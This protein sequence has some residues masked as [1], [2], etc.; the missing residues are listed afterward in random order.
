MSGFTVV[1]LAFLVNMGFSAAPTPL[2]V[3]YQERDHFSTIMVT[4]VYAAYAVGVIGA[5]FLAGHLS[6]WFGR[7]K[8][9]VTA[10]LVDAAS[11]LLFLTEPGVLGLLL[12]RIVC[13]VSIGLTTATATAY[14]AELYRGARG[15]E[16]S[17]GRPQIVAAGANLGGI[18][19]GPLVAGLLAQY[20]PRPLWLPYLVFDAALLLLAFLVLLAPETVD[21][22]AS[23][24]R[25]RPQRIAVP[26]Q[27][28]SLFLAATATG[29]ATFSVFGVLNSLVP[30]FL[31]G[32][33]HAHSHALAGAV[34]F[35]AFA[36]GALAQIAASRTGLRQIIRL[37]RLL[38]LPGLAALTAGMWIPNLAV[39]ITGSVLAG[40][41]VGL[42]FRGALIAAGES[43]PPHSR[44]EV[45]AGFF[46]GTYVGLSVPV[47]G[48][49]LATRYAS[50]RSVMLV[51]VILVAAAALTSSRQMI[52]HL[53]TGSLRPGA[54]ARSPGRR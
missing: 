21:A 33:L 17:P 46:L 3:L 5:L 45:L 16:G 4:V 38:L 13:G 28:R 31:A 43:A 26:P 8:V 54:A 25:Y 42:S 23:R 7:R 35:T 20:A 36:S 51:F 22:S 11:G 1:A 29:F 9:L 32:A 14:L 44:A 2:Y 27:A 49:G 10:L 15:T 50:P 39:F 24:P 47:I 34:A 40:A 48:L 18:G 12:A 52:I 6:D 37:G 53:A 41:G 19:T 30:S